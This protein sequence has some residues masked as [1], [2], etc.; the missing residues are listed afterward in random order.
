[1]ITTSKR[2]VKLLC[3]ALLLLAGP[4]LRA[5]R[6]AGDEQGA[7]AVLGAFLKP[8]ADHRAL[9]R[10]L[11]PRSADYKAVFSAAVAGK[12]EAAD[13]VSWDKGHIVVGPKEGQTELKLWSATAEELKTAQ[14]NAR[15][16]PAGY[17]KIAPQINRG[18]VFYRFKFVRPGQELGLAFDGL[19]YANGRWVIFPKPFRALP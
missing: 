15:V 13:K 9:T 6:A 5:A 10:E 4:G 8:G 7:R 19:V 11:R 3:L 1:M 14:G 17:A 12:L 2:P 18:V 16:F